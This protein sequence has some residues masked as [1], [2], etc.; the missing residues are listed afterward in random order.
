LDEKNI[1]SFSYLD[2]KTLYYC[3]YALSN[4]FKKRLLKSLSHLCGQFL[5]LLH[6]ETGIAYL[7]VGVGVTLLYVSAGLA[8]LSLAVYMKAIWENLLK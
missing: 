1:F 6:S 8:L 7:L 2:G 4:C 3:A 5:H